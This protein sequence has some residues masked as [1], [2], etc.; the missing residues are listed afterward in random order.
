MKQF[1]HTYHN[2]ISLENLLAAWREFSSGKKQRTDV[3]VFGF[4]LMDNLL[5]LYADLRGGNYRHGP[6]QEFKINDPKPRLIHKATV[7]D[8]VVHR[9]IYCQLYWF[10]HQRFIN[11]S[12]SCRK[13]KGTHKAL[14]RLRGLA[15]QASHN[16]TRT[17]WVLKCDI[18]KFFASVNHV[19]LFTLLTQVISDQNLLNLLQK[20][21][22]SFPTGLPLGNLTS[23]LLANVY[24]NELDQFIKQ[25]LKAK[26]YIRYADDFVLLH[27]DRNELLV[28]LPKIQT[29]LQTHLKLNLHPNKVFIKTLAS[30]VDFLGWIHFPDHRVLRTTT[31]RR[32]L[33]KVKAKP[34]PAVINSYLG[35][36]GWGNS[37]RLKARIINL[38]PS[39][40]STA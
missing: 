3:Q 8:R 34:E 29:F 31:E 22:Q 12:F 11:D 10:F 25:D 9:A 15:Y 13:W 37:A 26:F 23:Q 20:I 30:G 4:K 18:K 24:L 38:A 36:L 40:S 1:T 32:M 17:L 21:I 28:C 19:I 16:H 2:I 27:H 6:Y 35:L 14:N 7:R 39:L 33:A 5:A